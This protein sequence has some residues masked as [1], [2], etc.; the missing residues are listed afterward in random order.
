MSTDEN[1]SEILTQELSA[2]IKPAAIDTAVAQR[3]KQNV[4]AGIRPVTLRA[5]QD[6]I[7]ITPL[8]RTRV[9]HIDHQQG[10]Q[11]SLLQL[12]AGARLNGH[13]HKLDEE[14]LV[15]EGEFTIG[16]LSLK[17]GDFHL[18]RKG[19]VHQDAYTDTGCTLYLRH[20]IQVD[21][22]FASHDGQ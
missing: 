11:I 3:I 9:L 4:M 14:C 2:S 12:S 17:K 5:A 22:Y 15:L 19:S 18:V 7:E 1:L 6:W 16:D 10:C 20:E 8:A 13:Y 21:N